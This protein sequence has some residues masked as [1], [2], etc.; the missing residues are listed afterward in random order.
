MAANIDSA[1]FLARAYVQQL[2]KARAGGSLV[3]FSSVVAGTGVANHAAIAAAKG[4]IESL[5]RSLAIDPKNA[6]AHNYLGI[7]CSQKGWQENAEQEMRKAVEIDPGYADAHFNLAVIYATQKPP[8][9]A[10]AKRHYGL[11]QSFGMS[12][13]PQLEK[14]LK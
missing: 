1:F 14:L 2:T 3:L 9:K 12:K 10:L 13:D 8:A 5:T 11:A 4:A 7:A 6:Q